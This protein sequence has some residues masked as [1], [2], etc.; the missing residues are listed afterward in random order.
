MLTSIKRIIKAGYKSFRRNFGLSLAEIIII[1]MVIFLVTFIF[2][3]NKIS[4]ILVAEVEKKVDISVYFKKD[5]RTQ[6]I[7]SVKDELVKIS[8]VKEVEYV[9]KEQALDEFIKRHKDET[10]LIESLKEVGDNPFLSSLNIRAYQA[11]Q[12]EAIQRFLENSA[13]K[14]L[15]D[16]ID[17]F[18]RKPV[19]DKIFSTTQNITRGAAIFGI[20]L[21]FVSFLVATNTIRIAIY[22]LK[23]EIATM[24]LVGASNWFIR[25]PFLVQGI[26]ASFISVVIAFII[27]FLIA[28]LI[29]PKIKLITF[30]ISTLSLFLNNFW[31]LLLLQLIVGLGLGIVSGIVGI[32]KYLNI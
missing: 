19:I 18:Q 4:K 29:D 6:D 24:R 15:I 32:R 28:F 12:Y 20:I 13:Y 11:S 31:N 17:Y 2:S 8:E 22:H 26:I 3:F 30:N 25:G 21:I 27:T 14:E 10:V 16:K 9:S 5:A 23:D 7:F 1:T